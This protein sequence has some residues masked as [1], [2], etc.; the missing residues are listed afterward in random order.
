VVHQTG[1]GGKAGV[2]ANFRRVATLV[3]AIA[4]VVAGAQTPQQAT[5]ASQAGAAPAATPGSTTAPAPKAPPSASSP[6]YVTS[7]NFYRP[8]AKTQPAVSAPSAAKP[9]AATPA[10]QPAVAIK[11]NSLPAAPQ[12]APVSAVPEVHVPQPALVQPAVIASPSPA[13]G[14]TPAAVDYASGQLSVV[15][16]N[17]PLGF[18]LNLIAAKTG[19]VIDLVPELQNEPVVARLG[20]GPARDVLTALLDSPRIDYIVLGGDDTGGKLQR[21]MVRLRHSVGLA[22]AAA[23][24]PVQLKQENPEEEEKLDQN[25]HLTSTGAA[26]TQLSQQQRMANWQKSREAMRTAEIKQQAQDRENEKNN[27]SFPDPPALPQDNQPVD[28]PQNPPQDNPSQR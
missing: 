3:L 4:P 15:A 14:V 20:P 1:F 11:P 25:G 26:D 21:I 22:T 17:A 24:R 6:S 28:P 27:P 19:A 23:M 10:M 13:S 2:M 16:D 9:S 8:G 18:V 7:E 5:P 12:P